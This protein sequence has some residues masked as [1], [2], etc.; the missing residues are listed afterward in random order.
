[1][2]RVEKGEDMRKQFSSMRG[3]VLDTV[4]QGSRRGGRAAG[5]LIALLVS[6]AILA[7]GC[8]WLVAATGLVSV[9]AVSAFAYRAPAPAHLV[10][11]GKPLDQEVGASVNALLTARLR[12]GGGRIEERSFAIDIPESSFTASLRDGMA[13]TDQ[14]LFDP[15]TAQAAVTEGGLEL[16]LPLRDNPR[17]SA[18]AFTLRL[19]ARDGTIVPTVSR[20]TLGSLP[21]PGFLA[22]A[23]A[24]AVHESL[25]PFARELSRY[26]SVSAVRSQEGSVRVEGELTVEVI[27]TQ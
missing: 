22:N 4:R 25:A 10:E 26:A 8:A 9:P 15:A 7:L 17:E 3:E 1:M 23:A 27:Q 11:P 24:P 5:C 16:F 12:E 6:I 21:I 20:V 18:L 14:S 19:E 13:N 2:S